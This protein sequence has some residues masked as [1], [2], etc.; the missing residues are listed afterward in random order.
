MST[1]VVSSAATSPV[2]PK[3]ASQLPSYFSISATSPEKP[4]ASYP[5]SSSNSG[6]PLAPILNDNSHKHHLAMAT[7]PSQSLSIS[8]NLSKRI[9]REV[10]FGNYI[11]GST[12][13]EGEF[14]KVKLGWR[15]DGKQPSQ[16][17]I[18][19]I[20]RE[21]LVKDSESEIKIHREINSLKLLNHPNIVNLVEVMKS[22]KYI[23][24]VLEYAL[25][26]E[27]F[28]Y[29][30]HHKCLKEN[31]AKKL[32]AQ[33]VSGVDY[34]HS[35]GLVHRDLKLENLLLDKHKNVVISDFGF[36]N[37]YNKDKNDLMKTSCG[38]PCY[39]APELVLTQAPYEG[40][41]VDIWSL[42][43]ILYAMLA[44]YLPFDD[45][46]DNEDGAD[47][48]KLYHYICK[49]PLTFP[50]Y[51]SPLARDLLR[52]I[53]VPNPKKRITMNAI[54]NHPWL[55][56]Y[57]NLL[58]IRQPEWDKLHRE[59]KG[60]ELAVMNSGHKRFSM[61]NDMTTSSS[62]YNGNAQ[63]LQ[64][65]AS[66]STPRSFSSSTITNLY[67]NPSTSSSFTNAVVKTTNSTT[68]ISS[69]N[70]NTRSMTT[71][72][73]SFDT[74]IG[75]ALLIAPNHSEAGTIGA[76]QPGS[77]ATPISPVTQSRSNSSSPHRRGHTK[78]ASIS[79]P[80]ALGGGVSTTMSVSP[81]PFF[82]ASSALKAMVHEQTP[83]LS[84]SLQTNE[85]AFMNSSRLYQTA[86]SRANG[87][88][89]S[90]IST[91]TESPAQL[92]GS[93]PE[94]NVDDISPT[95]KELEIPN[96]SSSNTISRL[97]HHNKRPRPTSYHPASLSS[98]L[99]TVPTSNESEGSSQM[100]GMT[101]YWKSPSSLA[102]PLLSGSPTKSPPFEG[103]SNDYVLSGQPSP[104]RTGSINSRRNS[105]VAHVHVNG[106]LLNEEPNKRNSVLSY[107]ED[108]IEGLDLCPSIEKKI[109][110]NAEKKEGMIIT[111]Q[112]NQPPIFDSQ[113]SSPEVKA[114]VEV[115][116][117]NERTPLKLGD[118]PVLLSSD[119]NGPV[120]DEDT[121]LAS[122]FTDSEK[123]APLSNLSSIPLEEIRPPVPPKEKPLPPIV[124]RQELGGTKQVLETKKRHSVDAS[125]RSSMYEANKENLK[126]QKKRNRFSLLSFYSSYSGSTTSVNSMS[127]VTDA[128]NSN[129]NQ[130]REQTHSQA[131]KKVLE[132]STGI[133]AGS[134][135]AQKRVGSNGS[136]KSAG[137][138]SKKS[139]ANSSN[140][141]AAGSAKEASAARKVMDFF[142]RRSVRMG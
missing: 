126:Q 109:S 72:S 62:L 30:L 25:G 61:I 41:K 136:L 55:M 121:P 16:V 105:V 60:A 116:D 140:G 3:H 6:T 134:S 104:T 76:T 122:V 78:A 64:L 29:I 87:Y 58:S 63:A 50:E 66:S 47:I 135:N 10:R 13:G 46:P 132:P 45:D 73:A 99:A 70:N 101:D 107:L 14:G 108:K 1:T 113:T 115:R 12:L 88:S 133:N 17:A 43:V 124:P 56:S 28:D 23:G 102:I 106:V 19:L 32:F 68:Q 117:N 84:L 65:G 120:I 37:S 139:S 33:L 96:S 129:K 141:S 67:A 127:T 52:K 18:K 69:L 91:I 34:M 59:R 97:P 4:P 2:R 51:I 94:R 80:S 119:K 21:A 118:I 27:L 22:G 15:K 8:S 49:T 83:G 110:N 26:G 92:Q 7:L 128:A 5:M 93:A 74:N 98:S 24:I 79:T 48:V 112:I 71:H 81:T 86:S 42:G 11:L 111:P 38:S 77:A 44:G 114:E 138:R 40:R 125:R 53:I 82:S 137:S 54:R 103:V 130:A 35:K 20:K 57:A 100:Y 36:V 95:R 31:V 85:P 89:G 39:A 75:S 142:K 90:N 9:H 131:P 123:A